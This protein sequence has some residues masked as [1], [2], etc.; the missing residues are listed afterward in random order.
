MCVLL[1]I[2]V[3]N[4]N[5]ALGMY[6]DEH[7]QAH[8]RIS[9]D[10]AR[11]ADEYALTI[12]GLMHFANIPASQVTGVAITSVVPPL[13]DVFYELCRKTFGMEPFVVN[14]RTETGLR[15][16]YT[17]PEEVGGDRIVNAVGVMHQYRLPAIV[18]DFGTA[19]TI[20]AISAD[21]VY[22]GGAISPGLQI[23]LQALFERTARLPRIELEA[24]ERAIGRTTVESMQ[25]GILFATA[26]GVDAVVSRFKAELEGDPIVIATGGLASTIARYTRQIEVVD[27]LL[28][29]AGLRFIYERH[30]PK[31]TPS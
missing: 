15:I 2:D 20:D 18:V 30:H 1:C 29:L 24:P 23:S 7:L 12:L 21:G 3:G 16:G 13:N 10:R 6:Q 26:G 31:S 27:D 9:T 22:L 8:W 5:I 19:T 17:R 14:N 28:T 11:T 4:T 25:A